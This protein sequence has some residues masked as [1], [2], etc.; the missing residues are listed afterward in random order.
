MEDQ[1][2]TLASSPH[3]RPEHDPV[4]CF[5]IERLDRLAHVKALC[6]EHGEPGDRRL[7][8]YALYSAYWDCVRLGLRNIARSI[9][10]LPIQDISSSRRGQPRSKIPELASRSQHDESTIHVDRLAGEVI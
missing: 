5:F 4:Q 1:T 7:I 3:T 6:D 8:D 10:G 2:L 9:L